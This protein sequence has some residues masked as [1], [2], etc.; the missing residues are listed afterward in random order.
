VDDHRL[1]AEALRST[2]EES[3]EYDFDV[4]ARGSEALE[5]LERTTFDVVLVDI[6]LPDQSG[7][8]VGRSILQRYPD[9][10]VLALTALNDW[11]V[12]QEAMRAGFQGYLTKDTEVPHLLD[13][14]RSAR[15]GQTV[16]PSHLARGV[17]GLSANGGDYAGAL[18]DH[19]TQREHE[20]LALLVKGYGSDEMGRKLGISTNTVR[21]HVQ[22]ILPK[23]QV[24]SRLEAAAF[25]VRHDLVPP[26]LT[27]TEESP[28]R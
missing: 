9:T 25:A 1:F 24:H 27:G 5:M 6:G 17:S 12:V 19:L 22:N 16:V 15:D 3:D 10:I 18:A 13:A 26:D 21:S 14:I 7:L 4:A 11:R 8:T 28:S 2:L 23:L 20:I